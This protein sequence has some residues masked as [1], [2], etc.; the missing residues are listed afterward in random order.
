M[1]MFGKQRTWGM[2]SDRADD[3]RDRAACRD[4]DGELFFYDTV[5]EKALEIAAKAKAV[6]RRC[7]A[8]DACRAWVTDHPQASGI[9]AGTTP[10][11]RRAER[12]SAW[13]V[14]AP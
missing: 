10:N 9:W 14:M 3:W 6:C 12:A 7:P 4:V 1:S 13:Q 8:I 11:E 2:V 5:G